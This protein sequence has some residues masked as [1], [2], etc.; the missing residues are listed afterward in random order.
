MEVRLYDEDTSFGE[1]DY[2]TIAE[3][4]RD[5]SQIQFG[6]DTL[7]ILMGQQNNLLI[8][9]KSISDDEASFQYTPLVVDQQVHIEVHQRYMYGGKYRYIIDV[10]GVNYASK[11]VTNAQQY[12]NVKVYASETHR[13]A[14]HV[15]V[16]DFK[17]T[18]F[19]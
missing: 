2:C 11:I 8:R 17:L 9:S 18:N 15:Y 14:C 10:D 7:M 12:F 13:E 16:S 1:Y 6:L 3:F 5:D 19:L 4:T